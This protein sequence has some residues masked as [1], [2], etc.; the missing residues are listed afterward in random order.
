MDG[1]LFDMQA[2]V[3]AMLGLNLAVSVTT[4]GLALGYWRRQPSASGTPKILTPANEFDA[5]KLRL[6]GP[7]PPGSK[8]PSPKSSSP[9]PLADEHL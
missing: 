2:Y 1:S 9:R 6:S 3:I 5:V 4:L 7:T 8:P